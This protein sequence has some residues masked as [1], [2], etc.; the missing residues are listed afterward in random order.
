MLNLVFV[1]VVF[2]TREFVFKNVCSFAWPN[3][4]VWRRIICKN[5]EQLRRC[6]QIWR[7]VIALNSSII[8][9]I[10]IYFAIPLLKSGKGLFIVEMHSAYP[11][12]SQA[13]HWNNSETIMQIE[14]HRLRIKDPNWLEATS[15]LFTSVAED[16]NLGQPKT[17]PASGESRTRTR[18]RQIMSLMR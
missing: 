12:S 7:I 13:L 16:L 15:G 2:K 10:L 11:A 1:V 9:R 14:H 18:D 17:N 5:V 4:Q 8:F 3:W 6:Q